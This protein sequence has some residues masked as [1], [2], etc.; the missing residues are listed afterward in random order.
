VTIRGKIK[1][2]MG[3]IRNKNGPEII[4]LAA[5]VKKEKSAIKDD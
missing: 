2:S 1:T 5:L 4:T 3:K